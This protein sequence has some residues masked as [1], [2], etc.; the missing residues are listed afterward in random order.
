MVDKVRCKFLVAGASLSADGLTESLCLTAVTSGSPENESFSKYTPNGT[1]NLDVTNPELIGKFAPGGEFY[2]DLI[3]ANEIAFN[4]F[5]GP[6][7]STSPKITVSDDGTTQ[8]FD[9]TGLQEP[10]EAAGLLTAVIGLANGNIAPLTTLV[11]VGLG[12]GVQLPPEL[13]G[14]INPD[15][16]FTITVKPAPATGPV[17]TLD[18]S[19]AAPAEIK[20]ALD[21]LVAGTIPK[22]TLNNVGTYDS[23]IAAYGS[24]LPPGITITPKD[25]STDVITYTASATNGNSEPFTLDQGSPIAISSAEESFDFS[26]ATTP[27]LSILLQFAGE[28]ADPGMCLKTITVAGLSVTALDALPAGVTAS[29]PDAKGVITITPAAADIDETAGAVEAGNGS[30]ALGV[31]KAAADVA[32]DKPAALASD[33]AMIEGNVQSAQQDASASAGAPN[34]LS[35]APAAPAIA[36][37]A[38]AGGGSGASAAPGSSASEPVTFGYTGQ[39]TPNFTTLDIALTELGNGGPQITITGLA[40]VNALPLLPPGIIATESNGTITLTADTANT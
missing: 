34:G 19:T 16:T 1:L 5:A 39:T 15:G 2:L 21:S 26:K 9:Y 27:D 12:A 35:P 37:P 13:V 3:P 23:I 10:F 25:G 6:A 30:S 28:V 36:E 8:T 20:A 14:I 33:A 31:D 29:A 22:L 17:D 24:D 38:P 7:P 11:V 4:G 40:D 18:V 32:T